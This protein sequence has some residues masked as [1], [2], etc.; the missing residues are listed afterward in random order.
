MSALYIQHWGCA[1]FTTNK[2]HRRTSL[3]PLPLPLSPPSPSP[4]L[5][6]YSL[7]LDSLP[8]YILDTSNQACPV[9]WLDNLLSFIL[10]KKQRICRKNR[11]LRAEIKLASEYENILRYFFCIFFLL[12]QNITNIPP[13][14]IVF[15]LSEQRPRICCWYLLAKNR[16]FTLTKNFL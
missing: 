8:L 5:Q 13:K 16:L 7:G 6:L 12:F 4:L 9:L 1:Q 10:P 3:P 2:E 11:Y 14:I 15:N